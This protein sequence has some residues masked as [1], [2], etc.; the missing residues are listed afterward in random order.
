MANPLVE[1]QT[2]GQSVWYDNIR[3]GLISSGE[4][5]RL[6]DEDGVLGV[7][8][9]PAIFEKAIGGG[10]EY[11]AQI[12]TLLRDKP[13]EIFE[14]LAVQ[15]I[16]AAA[17]VLAPVYKGTNKRDGYIS[18]EVWPELAN[19]TQ[20]SIEQARKLWKEIDKPN[21]MIKIPA[22]P[23]GIP[24]IEQ[25]ISE[26]INVNVTLIFAVEM[27]RQVMDAYLKGLERRSGDLTGIASVASFFI[28][29]V[30]SA[31][32]KQLEQLAADKPEVASLYGKAAIANAKVA[33]EAFQE[34]FAGQRFATLR[35]RGAAVQ[36]PLW[37]STGTKNPSYSDVLYVEEI[38][39]R[40][41]VNTMPPATVEAFKDHGEVEATIGQD[42]PGAKRALS[43]LGA[44]GVDMAKVTQ[45][46]LDEGVKLFA[47]AFDTLMSVIDAK[48]EALRD[49]I[50]GREEASIG[51][52]RAAVEKR[53]SALAKADAVRKVWQK[54]GSYWGLDK[55]S[56]AGKALKKRMGWLNVTDLMLDR[57][58]DLERFAEHVKAA[59]FKRAIFCGSAGINPAVAALAQAFGGRQGYPEVSAMHAEQ[60]AKIESLEAD[61]LVIHAGKAAT[62]PMQKAAHEH[63]WS[64]Q[65]HGDHFVLVTDASTELPAMAAAHKFRR[66]LLDPGDVAGEYGAL[67]YLGLVA[68]AV[69]GCDVT[70]LL[71]R[72]EHVVHDCVP[73]IQPADNAGAWFGA[74]LAEASLA[75]RKK[76]TVITPPEISKFG[77]WAAQIATRAGLESEAISSVGE[78]S[79]YGQDRL[80]VYERLGH[81]LDAAVDKL[82]DAG[83]PVVTFT[84]RDRFDLGEEIFRWEFGVAIAAGILGVNAFAPPATH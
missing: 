60:L 31:V 44:A 76:I 82:R 84:L 78:S 5:K 69:A 57:S 75:G 6:I 70:R 45:S 58:E 73:L 12:K 39:G 7:T 65:P 36:R 52:L 51:D 23:A 81:D 34:T 3:R 47:D 35:Q 20:G 16:R 38:I 54:D 80:F 67:S 19:D 43:E 33:Y 66:V 27:H 1:L 41:T 10:S 48:R 24:A 59:G 21:L 13:G 25:L 61:T 79:D 62:V 72:A 40:D 83:Q 15:D 26:G 9:N 22:T 29:R 32:D 55:D 49:N 42:L 50:A 18:M 17:D 64:L 2:E 14:K 74:I 30:D 71:N 77:V 4:L 46:L 53:L 28:S 68:A 63:L 56:D 11:D 8:S 37:A